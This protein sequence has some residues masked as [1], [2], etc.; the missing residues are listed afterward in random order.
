MSGTTGTKC[1]LSGVYACT[2]HPANTIP[3]S[4]GETFPPCSIQGGH[5]A[6]WR[7]VRPA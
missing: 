2:R 6:T 5:G 3:L 4:K 7:L 1:S